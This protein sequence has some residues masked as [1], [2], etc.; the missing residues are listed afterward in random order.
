MTATL[1]VTRSLIIAAPRERVWSVLTN[2]DG[3][4]AWLTEFKFT[5]FEEGA[6]F[7]MPDG[8]NNPPGVLVTIE[9]PTRFA[10]RWT[11]EQGYEGMTLVTFVLDEVEGGTR[12]TV[13]ESGFEALPDEIRET[14]FQRNSKGWGYA[15]AG[16]AALAEGGNNAQRSE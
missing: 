10:F 2:P 8:E 6:P 14:P 4:G 16:L 11:A 7:V 9:R 13:T 3:F 15:L 1:S 5:T 12:V